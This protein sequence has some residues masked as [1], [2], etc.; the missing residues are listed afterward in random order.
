MSP[1]ENIRASDLPNPPPPVEAPPTDLP[2]APAP[3]IE[4][5]P[6]PTPGGPPPPPQMRRVFH[7]APSILSSP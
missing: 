7:M 2:D 1:T 3:P 4:L 5:P 6:P